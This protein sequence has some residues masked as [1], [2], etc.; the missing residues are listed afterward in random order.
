M[1]KFGGGWPM[2]WPWRIANLAAGR[3]KRMLANGAYEE[4]MWCLRNP[5]ALLPAHLRHLMSDE[6]R[7]QIRRLA[8]E[9][10]VDVEDP[11]TMVDHVPRVRA[12]YDRARRLLTAAS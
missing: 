6:L 5:D 11:A 8:D 4:M 9:V 2:G 12:A 1:I 10:A 7:A 3:L